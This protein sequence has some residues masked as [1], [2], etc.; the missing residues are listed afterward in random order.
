MKMKSIL[1]RATTPA[2]GG[3]HDKTVTRAS[4]DRHAGLVSCAQPETTLEDEARHVVL[5]LFSGFH[6][7]S[8]FLKYWPA[9]IALVLVAGCA[10]FHPQPLSPA[11]TAA[12][13]ESRSLDNPDLKS[14]LEKNL[15][16]ELSTWPAAKWDFEMLTLAAFY[17]NPSLDVARAVWAEARAGIVTAGARPNPTVGFSPQY[18]FNPGPDPAW[19]HTLNL[20]WPIETAG[21]RGA[22]VAQARHLSE[23]ARLDLTATAWQ[24]RSQ[25]RGSVIDFTSAKR[26]EA[27][28]RKQLEV[29]EQIV[30]SMEQRRDAGALASSE[31]MPVRLLMQKARLDLSEAQRQQAEAHARVAEALGVPVNAL[32]GVEVFY[33]LVSLPADLD[34][35]TSSEVRGQA[36]LRR[37][38]V[39]AA[40]ADY[41]A[42]ES[43]L[44]LEIAKQYPDVHLNTGYEYDQ[45]L[46]KWGLLGF[47]VEL[48]L[49][50]RNQ[51]P[52]AQAEARRKQA[53]ARFEALQAKVIAD[54]DR[55]LAVYQVAANSRSGAEALLATQRKQRESVEQQFKAGAVDRLDVLTA[56]LE[57]ATSELTVEDGQTKLHQA[58]GAL[59]D[60]VQRPLPTWPDLEQARG[61]QAKQEKP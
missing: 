59:E 57:L 60:A 31:I 52:I 35:L 56:Q 10:R 3:S 61:A 22:H 1:T 46:Q 14:F 4:S 33:D 26:R 39:L 13:L 15:N 8:R 2:R 32:K 37:P 24:V 49:L 30:A 51:G 18:V 34:S 16:R 7:S 21:K 48:P 28:L 9:I 23:S 17:Y 53:A 11:E 25:L 6:L 47:G 29:Q 40:L 27:L 45:G 38:D 54:I 42:S 41:A 5:D 19:V 58:L 50:N 43:A 55:G 20:D 44:K 36:L 12:G